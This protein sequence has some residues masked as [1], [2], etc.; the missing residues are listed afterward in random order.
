MQS[1]NTHL[2]SDITG[3]IPCCRIPSYPLAISLPISTFKGTY[4]WS[5]VRLRQKEGR[6]LK[7]KICGT[8]TVNYLIIGVDATRVMVLRAVNLTVFKCNSE[9]TNQNLIAT[10]AWSSL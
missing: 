10:T 2:I 3:Y 8:L 1:N 9:R 6:G 4:P 7:R 5:C